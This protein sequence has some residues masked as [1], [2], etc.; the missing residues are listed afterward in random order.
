MRWWLAL[1]LVTF[2]AGCRRGAQEAAAEPLPIARPS[3]G[4][5][6]VRGATP[7]APTSPVPAPAPLAPPA[8][9]PAVA[10]EVA[11]PP[12]VPITAHVAAAPEE[13]EEDD[14]IYTWTD[15]QGVTH[16][17]SAGEIPDDRR[18][19]ARKVGGGVTVFGAAP[20]DLPPPPPDE[21]DTQS[22]PTD[23]GAAP[24]P[25]EP[26]DT[27]ELDAQGLPVPGTMKQTQH[28]RAVR[29][30]TGVELD[31]AAVER[32]YQKHLR[33]MKCVE[34]DGAIVCG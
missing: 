17:G 19:R 30:A 23:D 1:M 18:S 28:L 29:Q 25:S 16:F 5:L 32:E 15:A 20:L 4:V 33:E 9:Q 11:P 3:A 22:G 27:P 26:G 31:P 8:E 2:A 13:P 14:G 34:K 10:L 24:A 6:S 12:A 7:P 21:P